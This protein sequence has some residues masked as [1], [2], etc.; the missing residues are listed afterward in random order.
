M[1]GRTSQIAADPSPLA[2]LTD[3]RLYVGGGDNIMIDISGIGTLQ[4]LH[5]QF[6]LFPVVNTMQS[7]AVFC[8][9]SMFV[10]KL[11]LSCT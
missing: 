9:L 4:S 11:D 7:F 2:C 1:S 10:Y 6:W 5:V 8:K 3:L